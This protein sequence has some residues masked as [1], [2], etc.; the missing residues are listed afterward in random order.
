MD[1]PLSRFIGPAPQSAINKVQ[2]LNPAPVKTQTALTS[3]TS[4]GLQERV[5][6]LMSTLSRK[7]SLS[8]SADAAVLSGSQWACYQRLNHLMDTR[9][10]SLLLRGNEFEKAEMNDLFPYYHRQAYRLN[11][12]ACAQGMELQTSRVIMDVCAEI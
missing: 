2:P 4:S 8:G 9:C 6:Q 10:A 1:Q 3:N 5:E 12:Q 7:A 11:K